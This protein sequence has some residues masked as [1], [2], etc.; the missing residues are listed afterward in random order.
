[1]YLSP[2]QLHVLLEL[3]HGLASPGLEDTSNVKKCTDKPITGSDFM[4]IER[5]LIHQTNP[6]QDLKTTVIR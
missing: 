4:R 5:E 3:A 6:M 1:L 2:R